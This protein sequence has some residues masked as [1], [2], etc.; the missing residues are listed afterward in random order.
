MASSSLSLP[1]EPI[2]E[3]INTFAVP[4]YVVCQTDNLNSF[5]SHPMP[6]KMEYLGFSPPQSIV[7]DGTVSVAFDGPTLK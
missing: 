5:F 2:G 6:F 1:A 7:A 3:V 4:V